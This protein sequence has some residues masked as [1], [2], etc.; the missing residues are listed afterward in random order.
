M[1]PRDMQTMKDNGAIFI[2]RK[3]V[4][5]YGE[6]TVDWRMI[7]SKGIGA[8]RDE[9]KEKLAALDDSVPGDLEKSFFYRSEIIAADAVILL[10]H[11]HAVLAEQQAAACTDEKRKAE[12]LKIA[13]VNRHGPEFPA[14]N[15]YE[16]M[17]SLL[18]YEYA[19]FME[20]NASS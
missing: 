12:L 14:R 9:A 15:L 20:Q 19:C 2:D 1:T 6:T 8:I 16:A 4:R 11:R 13:D 7:L 3:A 5:G 17:Q 10:A 18:T